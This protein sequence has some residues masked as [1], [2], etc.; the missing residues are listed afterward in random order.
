MQ[1]Q[2]K[3]HLAIMFIK[4]MRKIEEEAKQKLSD[5]HEEIQTL[6]FMRVLR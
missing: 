5:L 3:D 1:K 6:I 4:H 2:T